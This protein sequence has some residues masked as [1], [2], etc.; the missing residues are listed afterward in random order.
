MKEDKQLVDRVVGVD[1]LKTAVGQADYV[2]VCTPL[3]EGVCLCVFD[4]ILFY[5][6]HADTRN[7]I[8]ADV[9]AAMKPTGV[10]IN[11]GRG[12]CVDEKALAVALKGLPTCLLLCTH[13][14]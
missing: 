8:S 2:A 5:S 3:T 1:E 4:C 9:I 14:C 10:L 12:P 7:I 11:I 6:I 13:L